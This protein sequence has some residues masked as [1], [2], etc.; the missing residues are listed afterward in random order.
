MK[1]TLILKINERKIDLK[2]IRIAA[3]ILRKG[4]TVAFPTETVYGL[5]ADALN[6]EAVKK[7]FKAKKRPADNPII[8]H[9]SDESMIYKLAKKVPKKALKLMEKF[10]PG[11]LTLVLKKSNIV[12]DVVT[13]GL[14]TVAIRMPNHRVALALI[15]ES[16]V[17]VA[18]PSA[19][20]AGK[21]SPTCAEHVIHDLY[22][23]IDAIIDA[24]KTRIGVEST[25][26]DLTSRVPTLLRPGGLPLEHLESVIG[27]I[28]LHPVV[29]AE[30]EMKVV[31]KSPGMKYKHY[32]PEAQVIVVEG[33]FRN[34][35]KKIDELIDG[36]RKTGKKVGVMTV[37]KRHE[38]EADVVKLVGEELKE[39]AKNLFLT[40]REFDKERVDLI[41]AEGVEEKGLGLAIMNRLRK[42]AGYNV[43][44]VQR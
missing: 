24:G 8:V 13:A 40:L 43:I 19:N 18:A 38:Y 7:I 29:K 16:K 9:V 23:R 22:G 6:P 44:K 35:K 15:K 36:Y 11:P 10:W 1:K 17:P 2:K 4:G 3:E 20:L 27:K 25:V 30:R 32:A 12:P 31:A 21:P 26:L 34:V 41:L 28:K 42:A 5:G 33:K 14:D 37:S 39:I